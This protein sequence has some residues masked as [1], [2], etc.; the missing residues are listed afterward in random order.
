MSI[1]QAIKSQRKKNKSRIK[2]KS[3]IKIKVLMVTKT[4]EV[5]KQEI[6]MVGQI[7]SSVQKIKI[8]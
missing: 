7:I 4:I 1:S 5:K 8:K 6:M 2:D 3:N